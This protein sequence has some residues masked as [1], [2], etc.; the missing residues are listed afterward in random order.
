MLL[1]RALP[2]R[3]ER[4]RGGETALLPHRQWHLLLVGICPEHRLSAQLLL[5]MKI[6]SAFSSSPI[7]QPFYICE[8]KLCA[9]R[10]LDRL[11]C[12]SVVAIAQGEGRTLDEAGAFSTFQDGYQKDSG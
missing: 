12:S 5:G 4:G 1:P 9:I 2:Q 7:C 10:Q 11:S 3:R 6:K 8:N